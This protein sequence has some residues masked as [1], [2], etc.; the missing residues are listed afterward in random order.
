MDLHIMFILVSDED[1]DIFDVKGIK[2][3]TKTYMRTEKS[4]QGL[5]PSK[6]NSYLDQLLI[7]YQ[8][9]S[10]GEPDNNRQ[11]QLSYENMLLK[12]TIAELNRH[13][14]TH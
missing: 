14:K 12:N 6:E 10:K 2:N 13:D 8:K 3:V 7:F 4:H 9:S 1:N 5:N 11:N